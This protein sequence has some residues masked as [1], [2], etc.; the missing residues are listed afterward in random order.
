MK[1][2]ILNYEE[3]DALEWLLD[4]LEDQY[5]W[6]RVPQEG[7]ERYILRRALRRQPVRPT[8]RNGSRIA[9]DPT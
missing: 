5:G 7:S 1:V 2:L 6:H 3:I 4:I 9:G 8:V